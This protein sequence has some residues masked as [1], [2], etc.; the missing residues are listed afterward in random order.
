MPAP[1]VTRVVYILDHALNAR[2][3]AR[4]GIAMMQ[5]HHFEV[6]VW[7]L[8]PLLRRPDTEWKTIPSS[9]RLCCF[10]SRESLVNAVSTLTASTFVICVADYAPQTLFLYRELSKAPSRFT[11]VA[12][13][14]IPVV[15]RADIKGMRYLWSKLKALNPRR[16]VAWS[17]SRLPPRLLGVRCADA[18][19]ASAANISGHPLLGPGTCLV[20]VHSFD[21]DNYLRAFDAGA[22]EDPSMVV[23]LDQFMPYHD[24]WVDHED[25]PLIDAAEYYAT[26]RRF[27]DRVERELNIRITIAA[28]PRS[29]YDRR[30]DCFGSRQVF[31]DRTAELVGRARFVITEMSQSVGFA[32]L[33]RKPVLIITNDIYE[34]GTSGVAVEL[35]RQVGLIARHLGTTPVNVDRRAP[36]DWDR[37]L[38]VDADAYTRFQDRYIKAPGSP[39]DYYWNIVAGYLRSIS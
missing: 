2:D 29:D 21:Y 15:E 26:L 14:A 32:V 27:F 5:G 35:R 17:C 3:Y 13:L 31:R 37:I 22:I 7:D 12:N 19:L 1:T 20:Q 8:S 16:L 23:F 10:E 34:S 9:L 11:V 39:R 25:G 33:F 38:T 28:H 4:F 36:I 24:D 6:E 18:A 30:P